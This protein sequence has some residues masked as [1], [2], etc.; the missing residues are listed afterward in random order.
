MSVHDFDS[1]DM[2]IARLE[3]YKIP[4]EEVGRYKKLKGYIRSVNHDEILKLLG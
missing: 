4:E 1:A 3:K 2:V